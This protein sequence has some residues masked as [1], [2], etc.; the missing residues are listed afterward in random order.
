MSKTPQTHLVHKPEKINSYKD[1]NKKKVFPLAFLSCETMAIIFEAQSDL[2]TIL[3]SN[4]F[5]LL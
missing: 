2:L 1:L 5:L 4:G 3:G